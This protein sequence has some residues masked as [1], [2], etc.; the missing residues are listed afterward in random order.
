MVSQPMT[1]H[2]EGSVDLEATPVPPPLGQDWAIHR[3]TLAQAHP[4]NMVA[5]SFCRIL[6]HKR[7][8]TKPIPEDSWKFLEV[9][10]RWDKFLEIWAPT[11]GL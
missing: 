9:R 2:K 11:G 7:L 8:A 5:S 1:P 4:Q 10:R 6:I 3:H